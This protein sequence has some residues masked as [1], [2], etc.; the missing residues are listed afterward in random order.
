MIPVEYKDLVFAVRKPV[1]IKC[2]TSSSEEKR[3]RVDLVLEDEYGASTKW[4][5]IIKCQLRSLKG[6]KLLYEEKRKVSKEDFYVGS[7]G[8]FKKLFEHLRWEGL[9]GGWEKGF[10]YTWWIDYSKISLEK[11]EKSGSKYSG[12]IVLKVFIEAQPNAKLIVSFI[13][14]TGEVLEAERKL[15]ITK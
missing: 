1:K 6:E 14:P 4:D 8:R 5:G 15:R 2:L 9:E 11:I 12:N 10:I 13:L 3:M 7:M